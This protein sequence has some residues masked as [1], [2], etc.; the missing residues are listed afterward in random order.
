MTGLAE[1]E[2]CLLILNKEITNRDEALAAI[3][4]CMAAQSAV[5]P[6]LVPGLLDSIQRRDELGPTT[7]GEGVAIPHT[8]HLGLDRMAVALGISHGG[9][10]FPSLDGEP[11]HI[12]LMVL[13]PASA[14]FETAKQRIL[15]TWLHH[16][17]DPIFRASLLLTTSIEELRE[18]IRAED[19]SS[20]L[21]SARPD[22]SGPGSIST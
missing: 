13:T 11:V 2:L 8:W 17:R 14:A 5:D 18:A 12:V 4:D 15:E 22:S 6:S 20:T 21:E 19:R 9:L 3:L 10:E 1:T 7:I 16:L